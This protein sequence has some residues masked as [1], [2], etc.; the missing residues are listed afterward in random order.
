MTPSE[1]SLRKQQLQQSHNEWRAAGLIPDEKE[2]TTDRYSMMRYLDGYRGEFPAVLSGGVEPADQM[3]GN[4]FFSIMN[5]MVS[6]IS[7]RTPD[8]IVRPIGGAASGPDARRRAWI[9]EQVVRT[10]MR[11]KQF[12]E[13][14]DRA[15]L[16]AAL[17][18][19]GLIRHGFTPEIEFEDKN[20]KI[21]PRFKNQTPDMPWI[22]FMR[23]WQVRIDPMVNDFRPDSEPRWV[24]FQ[25]LWYAHQIRNNENLIFRKDLQ[26]THHFDLRPKEQRKG[27][28]KGANHSEDIMPMYE[29]WVMYDFEEQKFFGVTEGSD[30]LIREE[31]DW[32]FNWGQL[33]YSYLAF[34]PQLDTPFAIPPP[35]LIYD[36]Q[37]LYNKIWTILNALVS[38]TRRILLYRK[39]SFAEDEANLTN[40]DSMHEFI[41]TQGNPND[42]MK[43]FNFGSI[44]PQLIGLIFQ[45]KEQ[46]REVLGVSNFDRGQRANVE[47]A[48]EADQIGAGGAM[49]RA[50]NQEKVESF[51]SNIIRVA[52]RAF[53]QS[54][55]S[56]EMIIPIIG[57]ENLN[58]LSKSDRAQGFL[59]TTLKDLQGEFDY[60]V[61]VNSTMKIDPAVEL[62]AV[63][64][65]YNTLGGVQ[66]KLLN[67]R[68]FH[69]RIV[70]LTGEDP[71]QAILGEDVAE[72]VKKQGGDEG[73]T[74]APAAAA[75]QQGL[76]DIS[77]VGGG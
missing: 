21:I 51:W 14:V 23:P 44:D 8:P 60:A 56:R 54:E 11:E 38:R 47:T 41:S 59:K 33:P 37:I 22:Q 66:S 52:H 12:K 1:L 74:E 36:E 4:I 25:N 13:E 50:R 18:P 19:M 75:A 68:H 69:E 76:P 73:P 9:N 55:D 48:S 6:Q 43:E 67:Q 64:T 70:E 34:N 62:A 42:V 39:D 16:S 17:T 3:V 30:S 7:G 20:G 15:V 45:L 10:M 57:K 35:R 63:V 24:A 65:G 71:Q 32:P 31:Q 2:G 53:L 46:I 28:S 40:P 77:L 5:T 58:F 72:G 29:E 49:A 27:T 61:K 26:P